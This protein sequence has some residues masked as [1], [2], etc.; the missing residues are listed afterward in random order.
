MR[1]GSIAAECARFG[2]AVIAW[3]A[4][5]LYLTD[6]AEERYFSPSEED[7]ARLE[8]MKPRIT[9]GDTKSTTHQ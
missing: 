9:V 7:R 4:A 8:E 3:G 2:A 6:R 1:S 5:G